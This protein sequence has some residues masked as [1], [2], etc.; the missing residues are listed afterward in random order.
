MQNTAGPVTQTEGGYTA[1]SPLLPE[2]GTEG[3]R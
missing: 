3:I 1:T 2:L